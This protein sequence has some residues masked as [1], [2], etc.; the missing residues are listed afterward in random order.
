MS[1]TGLWFLYLLR[2]GPGHLYAG[3]STDPQRRLAEHSGGKAGARCLRGK[4]PLRLV[5]VEAVG[6]RA[7]ASRL[8]AAV[9]RLDRAAKERLVAGQIGLADLELT[10]TRLP[11][12]SRP[13]L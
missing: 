9:K 8:E 13:A 7:R 3:I 11:A 5:F 6:D 2:F 10:R 12:P 1:S 4:G